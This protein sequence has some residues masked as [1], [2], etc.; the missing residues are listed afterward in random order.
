MCLSEAPLGVW[1][2]SEI[3]NPWQSRVGGYHRHHTSCCHE[4]ALHVDATLFIPQNVHH[5]FSSDVTLR[6]QSK[7]TVEDA[8]FLLLGF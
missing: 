4:H 3:V 8:T 5:C 1:S 2:C 6:K 7:H